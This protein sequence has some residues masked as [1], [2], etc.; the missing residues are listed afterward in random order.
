MIALILAIVSSMLITVLMRLS[1]NRRDNP[2]SMLAVNYVTCCIA[3]W[4]TAGTPSLL[5]DHAG[6][7]LTL[8][9]SLVAGFLFLDF[10]GVQGAGQGYRPFVAGRLSEGDFVM[11]D[12]QFTFPYRFKHGTVLPIT[13]EEYERIRGHVWPW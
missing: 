5:P 2:T 6:L 10:Y 7:P 13:Q 4:L 3:A 12:E 11:A 9:M 1:E 8:G